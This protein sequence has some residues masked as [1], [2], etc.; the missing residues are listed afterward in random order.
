MGPLGKSG[1]VAEIAEKYKNPRLGGIKRPQTRAGQLLAS[2][3]LRTTLA[4]GNQDLQSSETRLRA[5]ATGRA[6]PE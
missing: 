1:H 4:G 6:N 5:K 2:V 3:R